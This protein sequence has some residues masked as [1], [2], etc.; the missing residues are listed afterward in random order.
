[1]N[2]VINCA[3]ILVDDLSK[4]KEDPDIPNR[5]V[6]EGRRIATIVKS[7]LSFAREMDKR[8]DA[9]RIQDL[10]T[11]SIDLTGAQLRKDGIA[12]HLNVPD[13]LPKIIAHSQQIQQV[14]LNLINNARYALNQKY[15]LPD[16]GKVLKIEARVTTLDGSPYVKVSFLDAGVG[17]PAKI[18][19]KVILPFFSTKP[20]G[21]GT[22]LGL[23]ISH[24]IVSDHGGKLLIHSREGEYTRVEALLPAKE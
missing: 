8:R 20:M 21:V 9:I 19:H 11:D 12:L 24:G 14:F 2:G 4:K 1:V 17:I 10:L 18:L 13:T 6:K 22:G 5:I 23:S 3:Q 16:E 15:P 7:L